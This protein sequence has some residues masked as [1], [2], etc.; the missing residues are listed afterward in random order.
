MPIFNADG[1]PILSNMYSNIKMGFEMKGI[2]IAPIDENPDV[3]GCI[4]LVTSGF[5]TA[6]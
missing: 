6:D 1:I 4:Y 3:W 2:G 5:T